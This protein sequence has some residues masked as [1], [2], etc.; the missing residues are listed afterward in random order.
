MERLKDLDLPW[1][2]KD[3]LIDLLEE[4]PNLFDM[5]KEELSKLIDEQYRTSTALISKACK[6]ENMAN[7]IEKYCNAKYGTEE[8]G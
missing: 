8:S 2:I 7:A 1:Y 4:Y 6:F 3:D 5:T